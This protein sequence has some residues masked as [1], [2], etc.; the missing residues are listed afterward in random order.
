MRAQLVN[1]R[2]R[3]LEMDFKCMGDDQSFHILNAVSPAFTC[4]F[5]FARHVVDK[6]DSLVSTRG[7]TNPVPIAASTKADAAHLLTGSHRQ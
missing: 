3:R 5:P 2:T 7:P 6:V 1:T 4:A